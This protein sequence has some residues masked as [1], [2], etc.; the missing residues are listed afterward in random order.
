MS[1]ILSIVIIGRNEAAGLA[2]CINAAHAA[3]AEV[4]GAEIIYVDSAST[5]ASVEI[6]SGLGCRVLSMRPE[7]KLCPSAG[8]FI[9]SRY[10]SGEFI[11]FLD[12]DT[13]IYKG[14]LPRAI[15]HLRAEPSAAGINGRID[16]LDE[17]GQLLIDAEERHDTI[18]D[19]KWLRGPA[20]FYRRAPL[21]AVGSFN[22]H[23]PMEE[24]AELGLRLLKAGWRLQLMPVPMACHTRCFYWT[25]TADAVAIFRRDIALGRLGEITR[26]I[27]AAARHGNAWEFCLLR[28]RTTLQFVA[29]LAL[30]ILGSLVH[31][32]LSAGILAAGLALILIKKRSVAGTVAF[33]LNKVFIMADV[34]AGIPKVAVPSSGSFPVDVIEHKTARSHS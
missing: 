31:V 14:F 24:E 9:G 17:N 3:A 27:A 26:T 23:L 34:L 7:W 2:D 19:T 11:L 6:A 4:G 30:I 28:I 15:Q 32:A 16:D 29:W 21:M 10:A 5:D 13:H 18:A 25:T 33:I 22:P 8:R 12:A 1:G 20:C